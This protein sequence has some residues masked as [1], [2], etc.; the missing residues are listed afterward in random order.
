[1]PHTCFVTIKY[2]ISFFFSWNST[3][4]QFNHFPCFLCCMVKNVWADDFCKS[5]CLF[6]LIFYAVS[7]LFGNWVCIYNRRFTLEWRFLWLCLH[8]CTWH[9]CAVTVWVY[10]G[11]TTKSLCLCEHLHFE[12]SWKFYNKNEYYTFFKGF[13][14][15]SSDILFVATKKLKRT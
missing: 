6:L 14:S 10:E 7:Q 15:P 12:D 8:A 9:E 5:L 3:I 2:K 4:S 11:Y 1:M 13:C